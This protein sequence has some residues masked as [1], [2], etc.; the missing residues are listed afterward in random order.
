[1]RHSP[2]Y[3]PGLGMEMGLS[4]LGFPRMNLSSMRSCDR[5][6]VDLRRKWVE[7]E[8]KVTTG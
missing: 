4:N 1:M 8:E 6:E 2:H 3:S 7:R 5:E